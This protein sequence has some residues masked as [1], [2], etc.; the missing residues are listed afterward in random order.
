MLYDA[1]GRPVQTELLTQEQAAPTMAG[2]RNIYSV[3][4]PSIGLTPQKLVAI[5]RQAEYG[6]PW[7]YLELAEEMEEKDLHYLAVLHTRKMAVSQLSIAIEAASDDPADEEDAQFLR[8]VLLQGEL[9]VQPAIVDVLDALGKGFSVTEIIWNMEGRYWIPKALKWRQPQWFMFDWISGEE[10]LVRTLKTSG[11]EIGANGRVAFP[12]GGIKDDG[13]GA[14]LGIQPATARLTPFKFITHVAGA[15]S[16][17]P[18]RGGL[19]RIAG[20]AYLFKNY[21]LKDWVTF[22]EIFGQPM[23]VGKYG[24]G[25][26][27]QDKATLLRAVANIGTDC[28]AIIPDSMLIEFIENKQTNA[29]SKLYQEFCEYI[30]NQ[31]SKG[32]LGQTLSTQLPRGAGSRAAAEVHDAVRRDIAT[33]DARRLCGTLNRD[34]IR[35]LID[36]NRGVRARY[37]TITIGFPDEEDLN[38]LSSALQPLIDRG[39]RVATKE[40]RDKFGLR[41]PLAGEEIFHPVEKIAS[42]TPPPNG[43]PA[44]TSDISTADLTPL[45]TDFNDD[46]NRQQ[47][48][49]KG[50]NTSGAKRSEQA[51]S[52]AAFQRKDTPTLDKID[53][54]VERLR[55]ESDA[56]MAPIIRP[57]LAEMGAA[58]DYEDLK[59]RVV[60][61]VAKMDVSKF[62]ELL[63]RAGFAVNVAGNVGVSKR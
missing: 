25:A 36:L 15:K 37:P 23:R 39:M 44:A 9:D 19:A 26:T 5:L 13:T 38:V 29:S 48:A 53:R 43:S 45:F 30:D 54:F 60:A 41:E 47:M 62:Q 52:R 33:D 14:Q 57:L 21:V 28:S 58:R 51:S 6:D 4:H 42:Q 18:I 32:V 63:A 11:P 27:E 55:N 49:A 56:A 59:A 10:I 34:L 31:V 35:P 61:A 2:I 8:E 24:F 40:I 22:A 46:S 20:W 3:E 17:L 16:G 50:A 7:Y 12:A 1:Y